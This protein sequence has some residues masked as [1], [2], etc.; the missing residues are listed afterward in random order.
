MCAALRRIRGHIKHSSK[1]EK[2]AALLCKLLDGGT[3]SLH[4][5]HQTFQAR[6]SLPCAPASAAAA[7]PSLP[8]DA[9]PKHGVC[10]SVCF[11]L[12]AVSPSHH[13]MPAAAS[14]WPTAPCR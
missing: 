10:C 5:R 1:F 12:P 7:A 8:G 4:F 9:L 3:V 14:A 13:R 2:A 11:L 6:I